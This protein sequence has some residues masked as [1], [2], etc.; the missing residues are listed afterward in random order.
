MWTAAK[1]FANSAIFLQAEP[2]AEK[3]VIIVVDG[4]SPAGQSKRWE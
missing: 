4:R 2:F 3:L 1:T